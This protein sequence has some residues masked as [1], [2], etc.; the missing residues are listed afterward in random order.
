MNKVQDC[1]YKFIKNQKIKAHDKVAV[2][3]SGGPDSI[4]ILNLAKTYFSNV[5]AI[6]VNHNLRGEESESEETYCKEICNT[7]QIPI[8]IKKLTTKETE[9]GTQDKYRKLRYEFFQKVYEKEECHYIILG[10]HKNDQAETVFYNMMKGAGVEGLSGIKPVSSNYNM[11]II[12][13]LLR[14]TKDYVYEYLKENNLTY[15]TDS[16]NLKNKYT[17][18]KIRNQIIPSLNE[19]F[20]VNVT[21]SLFRLSEQMLNIQNMFDFYNEKIDTDCFSTQNERMYLNATSLIK[22]NHLAIVT[23]YF[24]Y[25]LKKYLKIKSVS[26]VYIEQLLN[27]YNLENGSQT[28]LPEKYICEKRNNYFIFYKQ[29]KNNNIKP[30]LYT[31]EL[32]KPLL[33]PE[34]NSLLQIREVKSKSSNKDCY[35]MYFEKECESLEVSSYEEGSKIF[36]TENQRKKINKLSK[37]KGINNTDSIWYIK[38]NSQPILIPSIRFCSFKHNKFNKVLIELSIKEAPVE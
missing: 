1:F 24:H 30:F 21:E 16:S 13:P 10:H 7:L 12:R 9:N 35:Y 38:Q 19:T 5:I 36:Y 25:F 8:F 18:N 27:L 33:I 2:A 26:N 14:V 4:A 17:R 32:N 29:E 28:N 3:L 22:D 31:L 20:Q 11:T 15:K 6:H 23:N 34:I 37:E